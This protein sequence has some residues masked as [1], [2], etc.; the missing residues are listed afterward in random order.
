[1]ATSYSI[2]NFSNLQT[3]IQT[4]C[5]LLSLPLPGDPAGSTDPNIVLMRTA[6]NLASLELL[7]AYEW[8]DLT[9]PGTITVAATAPPATG[10]ASEQGFDLPADFYR[11][12]DQTH[13]LD[14]APAKSSKAS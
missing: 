7:N 3:L 1:M 14:E 12:I 8:A 4:C 13:A 5:A 10:E 6:A 11:F 9:K 2:T